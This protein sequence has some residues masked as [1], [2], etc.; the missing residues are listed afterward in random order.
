MRFGVPGLKRTLIS[1]FALVAA[2]AA[3]ISCGSSSA[4]STNQGPSKLKFRAFVSN[5]LFPNGGGGGAPVLNIVDASKDVLSPSLISLAGNSTQPGLMALSPNLEFTAIY[6]PLGN[7]VTLINNTTEGIAQVTSGTTSTPVP[8][9]TLPGFTESMFIGNANTTA[10]AAVPNAPT[11]GP[12]PGAVEVLNLQAGSIAASLPVPGAHFIVP[13]PDGNHILVFSDNSDTVTVI[14]TILIGTHT[15]PRSYIAGFDQPVWGIF[16]DNGT[17]YILNCGPQCHGTAAGVSLLAGGFPAPGATILFSGTTIPVSG[18]TTGLV[19][20]S[21]L[22]VAGTPPATACGS[23]TAAP[24]CGKLSVIDTASM[25]VAGSATITDGY[26][27]RMQISKDGQL[28]IGAH[29]CSNVSGSEVRGCLSIFNTKRSSVVVPPQNGDVTGIQPITGRSV[30]YVVQNGGLGI[31]DT[32]TDKL[33]VS[34]GNSQN[35]NGQVDIVGQLFD[36][37]LVD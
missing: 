6:S 37:K 11:N 31:Y 33:Q 22:Y 32:A 2:S 26:H 25:T 35:N 18:A 19:S 24:T 3:I 10:Y 1:I 29:G 12:S 21:A 17:A 36:V 27:D 14:S 13:S 8:S 9:I 34:P 28:F 4:P 15:D 16:S 20:G 23:G 30:V 7:S 5:P